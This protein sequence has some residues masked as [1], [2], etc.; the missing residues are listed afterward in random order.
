VA[1]SFASAGTGAVAINDAMC[2]VVSGSDGEGIKAGEGRDVGEGAT[3]LIRVRGEEA[4]TLAGPGYVCVGWNWKGLCE[5]L[6]PWHLGDSV[7]S[8]LKRGAVAFTLCRH[9][10]L[11]ASLGRSHRPQVA[12]ADE[13]EEGSGG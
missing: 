5:L 6:L 10:G 2:D 11:G 7:R 12:A 1:S 3:N 9:V 13:S 4:E 8:G